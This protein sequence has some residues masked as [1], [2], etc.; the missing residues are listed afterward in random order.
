MVIDTLANASLYDGL[1]PRIAAG[2]DYLRQTDINALEAGRHELD[3]DNLYVLVQDYQPEPAAEKQWEAHRRYVDIQYVADG[4]E[5]T[6]FAPLDHL[7]VSSPYS[8][9]SDAEFLSGEGS[10]LT[11]YPGMFLVFFPADAHM[12]GVAPASPGW[13]RKVVVKA[14]IDQA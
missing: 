5:R 7:T 4:V 1:G 12:P 6:G 3:G 10:F 13:V 14:R 8:A 2:L 11:V 9:E